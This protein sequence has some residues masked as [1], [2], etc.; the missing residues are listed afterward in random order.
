MRSLLV[1]LL[2]GLA[3][4]SIAAR[5]PC[6]I[7]HGRMSLWN[8]TPSV[9]IWVVGTKRILGVVQP[10]EKFDDLPE[11]IRRAWAAHGDDAMWRSDLLGDF[12]VCP[13]T[14]NRPGR[15]QMVTVTGATHLLVQARD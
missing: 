1:L 10:D 11:T 14:A 3:S 9:R 6:R 13:V 15:M 4:P 5:D 2:V 8:G 12:Q 7:V